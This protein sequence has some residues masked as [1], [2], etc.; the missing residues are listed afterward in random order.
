[1]DKPSQPRMQKRR[2]SISE[3]AEQHFDKNTIILAVNLIILMVLMALLYMYRFQ[4]FYAPLITK[5]HQSFHYF[6]FFMIF[7]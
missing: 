1:M 7:K 6:F 5:K 2:S 3:V 4:Q